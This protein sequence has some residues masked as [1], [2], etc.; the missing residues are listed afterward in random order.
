MC[1]STRVQLHQLFSVGLAFKFVHHLGPSALSPGGQDARS[2]GLLVL[3]VSR[4]EG[5]GID[6]RS[7]MHTTRI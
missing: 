4:C 1:T 7:A 2:D 5:T 6:N 3:V